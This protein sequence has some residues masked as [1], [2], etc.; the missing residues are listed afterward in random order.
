MRRRR[1][2]TGSANHRRVVVTA[3]F[4]VLS[5]LA[6][7][8]S[9]EPTGT[10]TNSTEATVSSPPTAAP[11]TAAP[12][13]TV[14]TTTEP[15][16]TVPTTT[17]PTTTVPTT[18][19]PT[20]TEPPGTE[21]PGTE[22]TGAGPPASP[23]CS[24]ASIEARTEAYASAQGV[25]PDRLSL[26]VYRPL[27]GDQCPVTVWVHGGGWH[28]GDKS[29]N[30]VATKA[31]WFTE[32]GQVF[33]AVNY[34]LVSPDGGDARWP[35]MGLDVAQ[36]IDWIVDNADEIGA[37]PDDLTLVGH[38][39]GAH[40]VSVVAVDPGLLGSV[41]LDRTIIRCVVSLDTAGYDLTRPMNMVRPLILGAFGD[42]PDVLAG[43][44]PLV[45][46]GVHGGPVA[47]T[48]VVVRGSRER[49][50]QS[51]EYA[52]AVRSAG[53]TAEVFDAG[54]LSHEDVNRL[55]GTPGDEVVT[56]VVAAF[57]DGCAPPTD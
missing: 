6:A 25:D 48:L 13:T 29:H 30:A 24:G 12:T 14:P 31:A 11:T 1:D 33:V 21:P 38:S 27:V 54:P 50:L 5:V 19:A 40:L 53:A 23:A 41:G 46:L 18:T 51:Q 43:A 56:P 2:D 36:A 20:T 42:D 47:D 4:A 34:R 45:Q 49:Y 35:T 28:V 52:T 22:A 15:T 8:C 9:A 32:R 17:V 37:D 44:S 10:A 3:V 7:A 57:L 16:T 39:A 55:L 26:D